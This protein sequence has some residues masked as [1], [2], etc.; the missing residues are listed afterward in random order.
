MGTAFLRVSSLARSA[1]ISSILDFTS[2][3]PSGTNPASRHFSIIF[4]STSAG[5]SFLKNTRWLS[6]AASRY[7]P[8]KRPPTVLVST[9][10]RPLP[11][12]PNSPYA[13]WPL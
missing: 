12:S 2:P 10:I 7:S 9:R 1:I 4:D 5:P 3:S 6:R 8:P 11:S 13:V